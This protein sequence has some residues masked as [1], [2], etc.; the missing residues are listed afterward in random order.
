MNSSGKNGYWI[1][2]YFYLLVAKENYGMIKCAEPRNDY[3][4]YYIHP[5]VFGYKLLWD[6]IHQ[7]QM[8]VRAV[9]PS[10]ISMQM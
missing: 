5:I 3:L 9:P 1:L 10:F 8:Y 2:I 4:D 6:I 7:S